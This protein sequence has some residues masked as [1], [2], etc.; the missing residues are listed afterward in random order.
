[1][2]SQVCSCLPS[3][4][5]ICD[6]TQASD[7]GQEGVGGAASGDKARKVR[8]D[9]GGGVVTRNDE[10]VFSFGG[11]SKNWISRAVD[12]GSKGA[13]VHPFR[14]E[15]LK[16]V[17]DAHPDKEAEKTALDAIVRLR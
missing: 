7:A 17:F 8:D 11:V 1:V 16:L 14:H 10:C 13:S 12:T 15:E 9:K 5:K 2:G 6:E 3:L 4:W